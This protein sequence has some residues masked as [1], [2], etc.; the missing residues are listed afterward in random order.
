MTDLAEGNTE[1]FTTYRVRF[2]VED[3]VPVNIVIDSLRAHERLLKRSGKFLESVYDGLKIEA[4]SVYVEE[5]IDGSW[6]VDF[7]IKHT[8]GEE[9]R[10]AAERIL[11]NMLG[12]ESMKVITAVV[13]GA[14]LYA[15]AQSVYN[16]YF[17]EAAPQPAIEAY[18]SVIIQSA[19]DVGIPEQKMQELIDSSMN[20]KQVVK[21]TIDA[22]KPASVTPGS[23]MEV[24]GIP[25]S[26]NINS[27]IIEI[28]PENMSFIPPN[29]QDN[30]YNEI[31]VYI[32]ASDQDSGKRGWGGLVPDLFENRIKFVLGENVSPQELHGKRHIRA[33]I[34]VHKVYVASEN[35]YQIKSVTITD[36]L[37]PSTI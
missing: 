26:L 8:V 7:L 11:N 30:T 36:V 18:N 37:E 22:L 19:G 35:Q 2:T 6:I 33:N 25:V 21:D 29:E 9:D 3:P 31:D 27:E 4:T 14:M 1:F 13:V 24:Q 15:G 32:S 5:I 10:E 20:N 16:S 34:I 23:M 17:P 12:G 28:L